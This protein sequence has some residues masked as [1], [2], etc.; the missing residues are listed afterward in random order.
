MSNEINF[1][2]YTTQRK[3]DDCHPVIAKGLQQKNP[4]FLLCKVWDG[5]QENN[6]YKWVVLAYNQGRYLANGLW[7]DH[8]EPVKKEK[9]VLYVKSVEDILSWLQTNDYKLE[10]SYFEDPAQNIDILFEMFKYCGQKK[11]DEYTWLPEWLEERGE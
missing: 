7:W 9:K 4:I 8:A 1:S 6:I 10:F 5:L 3:Y 11:P 2:D